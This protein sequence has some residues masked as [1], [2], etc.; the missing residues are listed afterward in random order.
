MYCEMLR[1]IQSRQRPIHWACESGQKDI[2]E[3]LLS[4]N[5]DKECNDE[6]K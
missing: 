5:C 4:Q 6:V 1:S 3:F 2:V